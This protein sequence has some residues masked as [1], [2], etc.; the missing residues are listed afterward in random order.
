M[1]RPT[2]ES[3][4]D[5]DWEGGDDGVARERVQSALSLGKE[6]ELNSHRTC[7]CLGQCALQVY[8]TLQALFA[9]TDVAVGVEFYALVFVEEVEVG[10]DA[11]GL[12]VGC[13][14]VPFVA[15]VV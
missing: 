6:I 8:A 1:L 15:V 10:D 11:A 12:R 14:N 5:L 9:G 2:S 3:D 4:V 13:D 7:F